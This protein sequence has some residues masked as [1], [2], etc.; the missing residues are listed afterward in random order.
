MKAQTPSLLSP[1]LIALVLA[2]GCGENSQADGPSAW[3]GHTYFTTPADPYTYLTQPAQSSVAQQMAK[4]IPNFLLKVN[5][6][7][8]D[9]VAITIAPA[10]KQ[11]NPPEQDPCNA[12]VEVSATVSSYPQI[13]I[14][15]IDFPLF[16]TNTP[17]DE[18]SVTA[19]A[20][21]RR[22]SLADV[23]PDGNT[24]SEKG[25]LSAL[26]DAREVNSLVTVLQ[27]ESPEG[28]C[29]AM[30]ETFD[31]ECVPCPDSQVLCLLLEAEGFGAEAAEINVR[32]MTESDVD[33]SCPKPS[34][35]RSLSEQPRSD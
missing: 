12:T 21:V 9:T 34:S 19:H 10:K 26:V 4:F 2:A 6:V 11:T 35:N 30:K 18:P 20:T 3:A 17:K 13:Q 7:S 28:V 14:G 33:P 22:F 32:P 23:L 29:A 25:R 1:V 24:T 16:I 31:T 15:P 8:E 5:S 27:G